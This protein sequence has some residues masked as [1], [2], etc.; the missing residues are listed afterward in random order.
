MAIY[1]S[2]YVDVARAAQP[3]L[4]TFWSYAKVEMKPAMPSEWPAVKKGFTSIAQSAVTGRFL[5]YNM[6]QVTQK[7]L[8]FVEVCC[9]FYVGE[10]IGRRSIIGYNV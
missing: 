8:V 9:W 4:A 5:D 3:R 2:K 6:R 1:P 7:A 10:I